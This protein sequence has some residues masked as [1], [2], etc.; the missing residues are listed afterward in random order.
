VINNTFTSEGDCLLTAECDGACD[1]SESVLV[2]NNIFQGHPDFLQPFENTCLTWTGGFP[3]DP[4]DIDYS[5]INDVKN[6]PCPGAHDICVA[7]PGLVNPAID[8]FDA[9]LL[10]DSP[11]ID[12]GANAVAPAVDFDGNPRPLDGDSDEIAVAD[13]GADEFTLLGDLNYDCTVDITDIMLVA[14]RWHTAEGDPNYVA[15][16]D[17]DGNGKIDIVDIMLVAVH[18]GETCEGQ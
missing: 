6:D 11:A 15:A 16:Y 12:A 9:H 17:L 4:F 18:W 3:H 14:A 8:A 2:R 1:S 13:I 5:I 7:S 10:P